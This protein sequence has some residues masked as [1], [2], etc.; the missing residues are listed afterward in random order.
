M[1]I[2]HN[3]IW[4]NQPAASKGWPEFREQVFPGAFNEALDYMVSLAKNAGFKVGQVLAQDGKVLATV[5]PQGNI[6]LSSE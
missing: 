4:V 6:H 5:A 1:A 2:A 3:I